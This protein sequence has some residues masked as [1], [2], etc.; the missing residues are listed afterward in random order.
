MSAGARDILLEVGAEF[1]ELLQLKDSDGS[2]IDITGCSFKA[3]VRENYSAAEALLE[4]TCEIDDG[5]NGYLL[6]SASHV[7]TASLPVDPA[8]SPLLQVTDYVWS[9]EMTDNA[10]NVQRLLQGVAQV[11][12]E[13]THG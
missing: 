7:D 4:L 1:S 8:Q 13:V 5:P 10:G 3:Q 6:M 11:S 2:P 9:L 12:P